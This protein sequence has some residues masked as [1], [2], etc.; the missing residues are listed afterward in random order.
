MP[1]RGRD[2]DVTWSSRDLHLNNVRYDASDRD[3]CVAIHCN[4][5]DGNEVL[6]TCTV[7][8]HKV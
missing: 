5:E 6:S 2:D 3:N 4:E 1:D 7:P 8:P